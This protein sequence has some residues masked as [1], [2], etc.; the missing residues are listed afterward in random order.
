MKRRASKSGGKYRTIVRRDSP[1]P[2]ISLESCFGL[3][4]FADRSA[5]QQ[6][7]PKKRDRRALPAV[8]MP[9]QTARE[10]SHEEPAGESALKAHDGPAHGSVPAQVSQE[11][12]G[13]SALKAHDGPAHGSVPAQV[14]QEPVRCSQTRRERAQAEVEERQAILADLERDAVSNLASCVNDSEPD[15]LGQ[16]WV[17]PSLTDADR[18]WA[19]SF[20]EDLPEE[21]L[22]PD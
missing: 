15:P 22:L 12:A 13:E 17:D 6:Q 9:P 19:D 18:A 2:G 1:P 7:K 10:A 5:E 21:G 8:V 3:T 16:L 20:F 14:S 4:F 11:A